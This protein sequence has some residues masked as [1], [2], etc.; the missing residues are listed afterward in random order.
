MTLIDVVQPAA[1]PS[2]GVRERFPSIRFLWW[3]IGLAVTHANP[4]LAVYT[5]LGFVDVQTAIN[6]EV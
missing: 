6:V 4:A 5:A 3:A 1:T 2:R